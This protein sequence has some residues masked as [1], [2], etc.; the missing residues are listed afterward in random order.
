MTREIRQTRKTA[1]LSH[2]P[3]EA[4]PRGQKSRPMAAWGQEQ[5]EGAAGAQK[6]CLPWLWGHG[7]TVLANVTPRVHCHQ[8]AEEKH[9]HQIRQLPPSTPG[10]PSGHRAPSTL[11]VAGS[12]ASREGAR[13]CAVLSVQ[14]ADTRARGEA[15]ALGGLPAKNHCV[16]NT[17]AN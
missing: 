2:I 13:V 4:Q 16:R 3:E 5:R 1:H 14:G 17:G 8:E 6:T 10:V 9:T 12:R 15:P 11:Q 7:C